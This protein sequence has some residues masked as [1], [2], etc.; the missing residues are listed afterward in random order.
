VPSEIWRDLI[1]RFDCAVTHPDPAARF[2]GSL[3]D[4]KMFA[5]DVNE[6]GLANLMQEHRDRRLESL[7][8]DSKNP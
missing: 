2:R 7:S 1:R 6:W 5:I 3:I 4:D 8:S